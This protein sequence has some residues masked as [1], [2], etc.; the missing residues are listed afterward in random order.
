MSGSVGA[1]VGQAA[2]RAVVGG[3]LTFGATYFTTV[4]AV[5][6]DCGATNP[7][8]TQGCERG[9]DTKDS[10]SLRTAGAA[11]LTYVIVRG[12]FEGGADA[13]RQNDGTVISGDVQA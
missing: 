10:K 13:K 7:P 2:M 5:E 9:D 6:D 11:A 4:N 12:G 3:V 1:T 8:E